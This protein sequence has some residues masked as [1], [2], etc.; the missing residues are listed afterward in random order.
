MEKSADICL[1]VEGS[2]PYVTGG[3]S[4][5][6]QWLMENLP[7]FTFAVTALTA[8][9]RTE[10][11]RKFVLPENVIA[12]REFSLFDFTEIEQARPLRLSRKK[13]AELSDRLE[14]LMRNWRTGELTPESR[15]FLVLLIREYAPRIFHNFLNDEP[16]FVTL[17]RIYDAFREST[18]FVKYFYNFRNIHYVLFRLLS[19]VSRLPRADLYHGA[20]TGYGGMLVCLRGLAYRKQTMITEHGI[21]LQEREL[22]ILKSTWLDEPYLKEMWLDMFSAICRWQYRVCDKVITLSER[23]R[24]I[25]IDYGAGEERISVIPNGID[26][27]RFRP[28]R[29]PR[30]G[31]D[32]R[33]VGFVGRV[34]RV[35][36]IKTFIQAIS[37]IAR[38]YPAVT[39]TVVG[40]YDD[41]PDYYRECLDLVRMLGIEKILTFTGRADVIPHYRAFDV[42][43]LTS[44]KEGM[45][46]AVMEAMACGL[47]VVATSV[48]NCDELLH[49]TGRDTIG[50]AGTVVR[51]MDPEAVA[52]AALAILGD[53]ETASRYAANGIR[54]IERDYRKEKIIEQYRTVYRE[55]LHAGRH[56]SH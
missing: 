12:Y 31:S 3:V 29:R 55:G 25:E 2:Y 9:A 46:L 54:R 34:D 18:G 51:V 38:A 41:A 10:A 40:P 15:D 35:K 11:E 21:Y 32:P 4:S 37:L 53:P 6:V 47:P 24:R 13:W 42:L 20:G 1:V 44:I 48:G 19:L 16:A 45:P 7:E 14:Q 5:W 56:L 39:A 52:D 17:T 8:A 50:P 22:D 28:A 43:L 33:H 27:D 30:C 26:V 49:G 36:D 23:N